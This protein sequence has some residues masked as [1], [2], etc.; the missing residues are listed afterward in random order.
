L[1]YKHLRRTTKDLFH[2]CVLLSFVLVASISY[3]GVQ[4]PLDYNGLVQQG[5]TEL[6]AGSSDQALR[7]GQVAIK[8]SANRWEAYALAGGAL[9]NLKR[10]EEAAD[11]LSK[12]IERAP[13]SKQPALRDLRRQCL[14]AES[15]SPAGANTPAAATTTSQAEIVLWKSI[16]NS[17]NPADFQSYLDQYPRGAFAILARRHLEETKAQVDRPVASG[18][19]ASPRA[20]N[21]PPAGSTATKEQM[22][23][24]K[25]DMDHFNTETSAYL[26]CVKREMDST[27]SSEQRKMLAR[28]NNDAIDAL[29]T[30]VG[31]FNEQA[32]IYKAT[33]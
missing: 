8:M 33:H 10:Y 7:S 22:I 2:C 28:K 1:I 5:K 6:Q 16:E 11:T 24:S 32:R 20:P 23:A 13:E 26:G 12:A 25:Q 19:C 30:A 27:S 3:S 4:L 17:A 31:S 9:M 15:G 14:L 18:D 29:Q 21:P